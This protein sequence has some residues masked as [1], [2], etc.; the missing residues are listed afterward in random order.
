MEILAPDYLQLSRLKAIQCSYLIK[1]H[2]TKNIFFSLHLFKQLNLGITML[3]LCLFLVDIFFIAS[4]L[5]SLPPWTTVEASCVREEGSSIDDVHPSSTGPT[6]PPLTS[7]SASPSLYRPG[8]GGPRVR[9]KKNFY[10]SYTFSARRTVQRHIF[11]L[12]PKFRAK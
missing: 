1:K 5:S 9:I 10:L 3:Y 2:G 7:L 6:Q 8:H 11:K 4:I 12:F